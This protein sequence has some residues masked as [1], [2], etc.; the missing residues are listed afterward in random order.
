MGVNTAVGPFLRSL[1]GITGVE[2][3]GQMARAIVFQKRSSTFS[4]EHRSRGG[5][6]SFSSCTQASTSA[7]A[8]DL[9]YGSVGA[10]WRGLATGGMAMRWASGRAAGACV[11]RPVKRL[12]QTCRGLP[13]QRIVFVVFAGYLKRGMHECCNAF[14]ACTMYVKQSLYTTLPWPI[15]ATFGQRE[16]QS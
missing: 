4:L 5:N 10:S 9:T 13:V 6:T 7:S 2:A 11:R 1:A 3:Y 15:P 8:R 16:P 12:A 14:G